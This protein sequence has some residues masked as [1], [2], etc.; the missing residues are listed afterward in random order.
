VEEAGARSGHGDVLVEVRHQL[1]ERK[2][3]AK[4]RLN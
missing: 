3:P 1:V 4:R 2:I